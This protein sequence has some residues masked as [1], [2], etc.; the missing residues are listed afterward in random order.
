MLHQHPDQV[1]R[2]DMQSGPDPMAFPNPFFPKHASADPSVVR[3]LPGQSPA[4]NEVNGLDPR[5][6]AEVDPDR[7][8]FVRGDADPVHRSLV[9]VQRHQGGGGVGFGSGAF[10][11][12]NRSVRGDL[13]LFEANP[14]FLEAPSMVRSEVD[15][16]GTPLPVP[17]RNPDL[18]GI[19]VQME[20]RRAGPQEPFPNVGNLGGETTME[21]VSVTSGQGDG[22]PRGHDGMLA[23]KTI[24]QGPVPGKP[25]TRP[26]GRRV[27]LEEMSDGGVGQ[28]PK[29]GHEAE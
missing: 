5:D 22:D 20:R 3:L 18:T 23:G 1:A 12:E 10:Q 25:G 11:E 14:G 9:R 21:P 17:K 29:V 6:L 19:E 7:L 27:D 13:E 28:E 24:H 16:E 26:F 8:T 15:E 4:A 2:E